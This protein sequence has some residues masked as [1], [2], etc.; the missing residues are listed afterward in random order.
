MRFTSLKSLSFGLALASFVAVG[1]AGAQSLVGVNARLNHTLDT[2]GAAVGEVITATLDGGVTADGVKLPRGT[3][4]IGKVA[5]VKAE[6]N[7]V[8]VTLVFDTAKLKSGKQLPVKVTVLAAYEAGEV[9]TQTAIAPPPEHVNNAGAF[10]QEP[11]A[12][13]NVSIR[14]AVK[15]SDSGRFSSSNGNFKLLAGTYLQVGI[16]PTGT[17]APTSAAE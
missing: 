6:G 13:G 7:A 8:S 16:A 12:L 2:K 11:G 5:E 15:D 10:D 1:A 9:G 3:E 17:N 14:S 4:L